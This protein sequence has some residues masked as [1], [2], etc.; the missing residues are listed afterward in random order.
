MAP[1]QSGLGGGEALKQAL[2]DQSD[3]DVAGKSVELAAE[4]VA[5]GFGFAVEEL[6]ALKPAQG[7]HGTHPE[8]IRPSADSVERLL[9]TDLDLEAQGVEPDDLR[10]SEGEIGAQEQDFS[11]LGMYDRHEAHE[12]ADRPPE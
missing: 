9:E 7:R 2:G 1:V 11:A 10:R 6:V 12:S 8:V 3:L 5:I 4:Y